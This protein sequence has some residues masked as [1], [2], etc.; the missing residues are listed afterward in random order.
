VL[1]PG[2]QVKIWGTYDRDDRSFSQ[3]TRVQNW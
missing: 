2:Q 3:T 1:N